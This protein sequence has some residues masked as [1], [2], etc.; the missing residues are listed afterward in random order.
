MAAR[1]DLLLATNNFAKVEEIRAMLSEL[2]ITFHSLGEFTGIRPVEETGRSYVANARMKARSYAQQTGLWA[3]ADDS[4][5]EV[6]ALD[7]APGVISA[8]YAGAGASDRDRIGFLLSQLH[9]Q[10]KDDRS[11][12][13]VC[14]AVLANST[15]SFVRVS[16]GS[17]EGQIID[18]PRGTN[19]FGYDPIFVPNGF[20]QTFAELPA[21]IKNVISHRAK[22]L[23]AMR[24][25]LR[26]WLAEVD[27]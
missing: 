5:L 22:A 12:R 19:G 21:E 6:T 26:E 1:M 14:A 11:A 16:S 27:G 2:R 3:L 13:F 23:Q 4:G 17:C 7:G 15:D 24:A 9:R 18:T 10:G 20:N 8:R 25:F